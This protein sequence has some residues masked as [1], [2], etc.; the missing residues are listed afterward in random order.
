MAKFDEEVEVLIGKGTATFKRS[1]KSLM[2]LANILGE[3]RDENGAR[4]I[5][6]DRLVHR[7]NESKFGSWKLS[8]AISTI[9]IS[10]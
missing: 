8:G 9:L 7:P 10:A 5:F 2:V 3:D 4:R 1:G 6:L